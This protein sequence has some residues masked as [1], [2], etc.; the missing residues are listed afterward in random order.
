MLKS[1]LKKLCGSVLC[2][3]LIAVLALGTTSVI[4]QAGE[5]VDDIINA[6]P[7]IY[8]DEDGVTES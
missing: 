5:T 3:T 6:T 4:V 8:D 1:M 2:A 7:F